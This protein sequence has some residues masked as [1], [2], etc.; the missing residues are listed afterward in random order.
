MVDTVAAVGLACSGDTNN[1]SLVDYGDDVYQTDAFGD[2]ILF[3]QP[4]PS[5]STSQTPCSRGYN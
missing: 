1:K 5:L 3:N 4:E 2:R